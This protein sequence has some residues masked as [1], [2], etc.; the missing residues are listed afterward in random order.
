LIGAS[1]GL[2]IL[3]DASG[4]ACVSQSHNLHPINVVSSSQSD[5]VPGLFLFLGAQQRLSFSSQ[6]NT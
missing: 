5:P 1:C 4:I 6:S 3:D 2:R